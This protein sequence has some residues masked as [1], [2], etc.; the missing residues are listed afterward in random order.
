MGGGLVFLPRQGIRSPPPSPWPGPTMRSPA[1][2][3]ETLAGAPA[4][5]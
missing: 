5:T 3:P 2:A 4:N 1:C